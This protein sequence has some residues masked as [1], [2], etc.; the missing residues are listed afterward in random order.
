M[1]PAVEVAALTKVYPTRRGPVSAISDASFRIEPGEVVGLLGPNGAGKTTT[2]KCLCTLVRVTSGQARVGGFDVM[3]Q[4]NRAV[5]QIAAVFEANRNLRL[6]LTARQ[7]LQ[8]YASLQGSTWRH[9]GEVADRLLDRFRLS[10]KANSEV[11]KLS[12]G[13]QQKLAL[14]AALARE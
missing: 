10:H 6:D 13:M 8:L 7:N 14:A 4:P 11:G 12:R 3:S 9:G 1:E 5:A 2:I